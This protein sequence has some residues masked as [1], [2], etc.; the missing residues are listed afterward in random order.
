MM[1]NDKAMNKII[2]PV[3]ADVAN[4]MVFSSDDSPGVNTGRGVAAS[5]ERT[6]LVAIGRINVSVVERTSMVFCKAGATD[7][8][9]RESKSLGVSKMVLVGRIVTA[10]VVC[11]DMEVEVNSEDVSVD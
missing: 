3:E 5:V 9:A 2:D 10:K 7:E 6:L 11:D 4:M 1:I 8:V